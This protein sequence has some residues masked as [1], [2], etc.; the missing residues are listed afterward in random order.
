MTIVTTTT[1]SMT[2]T[3]Q[4]FLRI[5]GLEKSLEGTPRLTL[6][7]VKNL[8]DLVVNEKMKKAESR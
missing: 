4:H 5:D 6:R 7:R 2:T 3:K 1:T 8:A